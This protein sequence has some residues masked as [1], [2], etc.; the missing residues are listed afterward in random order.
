M[1]AA[2]ASAVRPGDGVACLDVVGLSPLMAHAS[3]IPEISIGLIDGPVAITHPDL[4]AENIQQVPGKLAG[5]CADANNAACVHGT[6]VAGVLLARRG[7]MAPAICPGCSLL[8]R[9]IFAEAA[10]NGDQMPSATATDLSHAIVDVIDAGAR[11]I[12]LSV[13]I[14]GPSAGAERSL[15]N[16]SETSK[17]MA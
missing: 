7:S 3:G 11:V 8:V 17:L 16:E 14:Q 15:R 12:N 9:P 2:A 5:A 13:A 1:A 6:F 4:P 10:S